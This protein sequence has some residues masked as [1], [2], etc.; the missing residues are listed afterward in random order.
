MFTR[1]KSMKSADMARNMRITGKLRGDALGILVAAIAAQVS[2]STA[3]QGLPAL[4]PILASTFQLSTAGVGLLLGVISL[5]TATSVILWG[6]LADRISD[7]LVALLGLVGTGFCFAAAAFVSPSHLAYVFLVLAGFMM[8]APTVSM[9]RRIARNFGGKDSLGFVL[10][11]RQAAVPFGG[12]IGG[13]VLA[14]YAVHQGLSTSLY[15]LAVLIF[16]GALVVYKAPVGIPEPKRDSEV[17]E[18]ID[19]KKFS[20]IVVAG[21]FFHLTQLGV[22]ALLTL[23]LSSA[24]GWSP[25]Q[26]GIY[27]ALMMA[28]V[29][30]L[31]IGLGVLS[32]R[33]PIRRIR[34]QIVCALLSGGLLIACAALEHLSLVVPLLFVTAVAS[35]SWNGLL[36]TTAVNL[37]H[38]TR[39]GTTQGVLLSFVFIFGGISPIVMSWLAQ[40][41][42][43]QLAWV[44][45]GLCSFAAAIALR[46]LENPIKVSSVGLPA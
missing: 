2:V 8:A 16:V 22:V 32:D 45:M 43:W 11:S 10:S 33:Y 39:V 28:C 35:M 46:F 7:R 17:M 5:G 18:S 34:Y 15:I 21:A 19:W 1:L 6:S 14:S 36:F 3:Q 29:I 27:Y 41:F 12:V 38:P 26:A 25:T 42:S 9:T 23:Y 24:R 40:N 4:G 30:P 37:V 20:P 31:R 13:F 44:V